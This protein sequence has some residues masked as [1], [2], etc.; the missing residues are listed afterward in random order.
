LL[1]TGRASD[2]PADPAWGSVPLYRWLAKRLE[3]DQ[4]VA[5]ELWAR[6]PVRAA[7]RGPEL[8]EELASPKEDVDPADD[9]ASRGG[10]SGGAAS[11]RL[12]SSHVKISYAVFCL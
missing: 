3:R 12:N 8:G 5:C 9:R 6:R 2:M 7:A 11:T 1:L 10:P 4:G